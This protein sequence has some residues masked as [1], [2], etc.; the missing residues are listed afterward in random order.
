MNSLAAH[1]G[2]IEF[3]VNCWIIDVLVFNIA[4]VFFCQR[5][6]FVQWTV[7]DHRQLHN[8]GR[9]VTLVEVHRFGV[10]LAAFLIAK[11]FQV[12]NQK[13]VGRM[14]AHQAARQFKLAK[15]IHLAAHG[16]F[17]INGIFL[18]V[19]ILR[20]KLGRFKEIRETIQ[21]FAVGIVINFKHV[22]GDI[23]P[24]VG[25]VLATVS[26]HKLGIPFGIRVALSP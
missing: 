25:I 18:F 2:K 12:T 26:G 10:Q 11:G 13:A 5:F 4:E 6:H 9:V 22:V 23:Q 21:R 24:R 14:V 3:I 7:A 1:F 19:G 17:R 16:P 8:V 15:V 20:V